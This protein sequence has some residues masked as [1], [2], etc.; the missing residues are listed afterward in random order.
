AAMYRGDT[1]VMP[2]ELDPA[3]RRLYGSLL[4]RVPSVAAE[5]LAALGGYEVTQAALT[6]APS[7]RR[8]RLAAARRVARRLRRTGLSGG[9]M[10]Y[11]IL[12]G[13]IAHVAG[14]DETALR[15]LRAASIA[16]EA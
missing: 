7:V 13:G 14:D 3:W 9:R 1:E 15:H 8:A 10:A 16:V 4:L 6:R 12:S 11:D 2:R 5:A